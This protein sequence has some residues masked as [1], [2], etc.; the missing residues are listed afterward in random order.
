MTSGIAADVLADPVGVIVG[1]VGEVEQH[2]S[3]TVGCVQSCDREL[4]CAQ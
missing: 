3:P 1:L 2:L 4:G